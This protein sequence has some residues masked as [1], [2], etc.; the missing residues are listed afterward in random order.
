MIDDNDLQDGMDV[1]WSPD[2]VAEHVTKWCKQ[3]ESIEGA[4][5][6]IDII[7]TFDEYG[8]SDHCNHQD[9]FRGVEVLMK[10]KMIDVEVL[11]LSSVHLVR[12]Y[13][14]IVDVNFVWL[15]EWHTFNYNFC[16]AYNTLAEHVT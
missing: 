9:V 6:K 3:K 12:K 5:G 7:V 13:I 16:E 4:E 14:A 8:V 11:A 10:K 2:L 1:N 15:D